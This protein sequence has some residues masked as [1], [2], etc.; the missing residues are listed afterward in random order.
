MLPDEQP[1]EYILEGLD[2]EMAFPTQ[3]KVILYDIGGVVVSA[4]AW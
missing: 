1:V 4:C 2:A 3:P